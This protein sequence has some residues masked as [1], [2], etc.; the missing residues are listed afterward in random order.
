MG[1]RNSGFGHYDGIYPDSTR[2]F[3]GE[4]DPF[5]DK[6]R[7]VSGSCANGVS[8]GKVL[9]PLLGQM[10]AKVSLKMIR[11]GYVPKGNGELEVTVEP[12]KAPLKAFVKT[13]RGEIRSIQGISL[14]SHLAKQSVAR[15]MAE[16]SRELLAQKGY[17]SLTRHYRGR[18]CRPKRRG[19]AALGRK[20]RRLPAW[21]RQGGKARPQFGVNCA[22]R[23]GRPFVGYLNRGHCGQVCRR[24]VDFV[25]GPC[26]RTKPL[27]RSVPDRSHRIQLVAD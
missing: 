5:Y 27:Y 8:H 25:R 14:A 12:A 2:S 18:L 3:Y 11:P 13:E 15:R 19:S 17:R 23:S 7:P 20:H 24:P 26:T 16:R 6:R 21:I 22:E 4:E 1:Y 10:G 9:A